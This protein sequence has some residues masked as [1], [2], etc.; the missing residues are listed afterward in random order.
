MPLQDGD[1]SRIGRYRLTARLGSGGMG[2]VY[3]GVAGDGSHVAVKML[4]PELSDDNQF[5]A[6][7]RREVASL[8]RVH[9]ICTV[10]VIEADTESPRPFLVTEYVS[11]P[12][13]AEHVGAAGPL[14]PAMLQGLATGLAEA[15][16]AIHEAGVV[17]R[18]LKPA[19]VLLTPAG[20]K[21][22]DFG[23]AQSLDSTAVTRAGITVGSPGFM[24]PEQI[25]GRAGQAADI[26]TWGLTIAYAA[27]GEPP[28]GT[29]PADAILYRI[30]H[31]SPD[32]AAVPPELRPL[33][34]AALARYPDERPTARALLAQLTSEAAH[35]HIPD[36]VPTQLVLSRTWLLPAGSSPEPAKPRR[37]SRPGVILS[38]AAL[39]A[40]A[41]GAGAALLPGGTGQSGPTTTGSHNLAPARSATS[42][43]TGAAAQPSVSLTRA[44]DLSGTAVSADSYI[45]KLGFEPAP[46]SPPWEAR[47]PLNVIVAVYTGGA[48][49]PMKAFFFGDGKFIGTDTADGSAAESARR[50]NGDTITVQYDLYAAGDPQ[51][52]PSGGTDNVRFSWADGQL[53]TLDP[54]PPIAQRF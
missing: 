4:R 11:G 9:G 39:L 15:L 35:T 14:Q 6:R 19:N 50:L 1:P 54:I 18:D 41:A 40:A 48:S 10:R 42:T 17:H 38:S 29:G 13:L 16:T 27:K 36:E 49:G 34:A 20:P 22:I 53:Q 43:P 24:A 26:F 31:D 7:F 33:V 25:T 45:Y 28:F 12:S 8:T 37:L 52:C 21:V 44:G 2:V 30:L 32:V 46:S 47:A 3:L 51:C 5:R 23:I